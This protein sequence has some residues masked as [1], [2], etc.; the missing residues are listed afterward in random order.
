[1]IPQESLIAQDYRLG[2]VMPPSGG[3]A[4]AVSPTSSTMFDVEKCSHSWAA[5]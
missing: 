5:F 1:M 3:S 2:T 4:S